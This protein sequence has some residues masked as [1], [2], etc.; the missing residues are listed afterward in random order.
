MGSVSPS[1]AALIDR[2]WAETEEQEYQHLDWAADTG[3]LQRLGKRRRWGWVVLFVLVAALGLGGW[4]GWQ[5]YQQETQARSLVTFEQAVEHV[6]EATAGLESALAETS[7]DGDALVPILASL[8]DASRDLFVASGDLD[9][10]VHE[11]VR[12]EAAEAAARASELHDGVAAFHAY[13]ALVGQTLDK[14]DLAL[15][16]GSVEVATAAASVGDWLGRIDAAAAEA[17]EHPL[18]EAHREL[19]ADLRPRI[20]DLT[21]S[22]LTAVREED[23]AAAVQALSSLEQTLR[24]LRTELEATERDVVEWAAERIEAVR[25]YDLAVSVPG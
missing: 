14:P 1:S 10:A 17:P 2:L 25:S 9:P 7:T 24:E 11:S 13:D 5:Y 8:D 21:A 6:S 22:Y 23:R 12:I 4:F 19:M 16:G 20:G 3:D 15:S 18:L